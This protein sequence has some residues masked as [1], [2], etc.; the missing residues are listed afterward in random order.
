M[1]ESHTA[2][3]RPVNLSVRFERSD[4][5]FGWLIGLAALFIALAVVIFWAMWWFYHNY[6]LFQ[7]AIKGPR[8]PL[9]AEVQDQ[10]PQIPRLEQVDRMGGIAVHESTESRFGPEQP[11]RNLTREQREQIEQAINRLV[12]EKQLPVRPR[13]KGA[14]KDSFGLF[15]WGESNSGRMLREKPR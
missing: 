13:P 15:D 9:S 8:S 11:P 4:L 12:Q 1:V 14:E 2:L 6:S 7:A 5:S 3:G 10:L